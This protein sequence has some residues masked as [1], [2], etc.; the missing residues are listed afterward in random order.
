MYRKKDWVNQFVPAA[1]GKKLYRDKDLIAV[2]V[3]ASKIMS[4]W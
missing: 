2:E 1:Q 4:L 3:G